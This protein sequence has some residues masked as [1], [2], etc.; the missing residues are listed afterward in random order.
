MNETSTVPSSA[1]GPWQ[2]V[3]VVGAGVIGASW[4]A[5]FLAK[6]LAV[7]ISDPAPDV[8]KQ[9]RAQL[10]EAV[11]VLRELGLPT[12]GLDRKL[13]FEVNL[14]QAV[15][16]ADVVQ[17]NGPERLDVKRDLFSRIEKAAPAGAL[18]ASSTSGIRVT[19]IAEAL[20]HPGRLVIGHPFNPPH[21]VPLVE[22]VGGEQTD[23]ETVRRAVD[24]Y[25]ALGKKPLVLRKEVPGFV[26]NRLQSA[27]FREAINLVVEGVVTEQ[28]LDD[29]VTSSIGL[30]WAVAGPFR[31]FHLGGGPGGLPAFFQHLGPALEAKWRDL[32]TPQLDDETVKLLSEQAHFGASFEELQT[33]RDKAQIKVMRALG[34]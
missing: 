15:A 21:L 32:G 11:P 26:A 22:V 3:T 12:D 14:E 30:R 31:S 33:E 28:E 9:V 6:G 27:L 10:D 2:N 24:F 17:E 5:L 4:T 18:L 7:T 16:N 25:T 34:E 20:E 19:D 13:R 23:P 1:P 29:I 8:A